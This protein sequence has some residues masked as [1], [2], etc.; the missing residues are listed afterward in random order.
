MQEYIELIKQNE[1]VG[2]IEYAKKQL[3]K[4]DDD[5]ETLI[6]LSKILGLIAF[7]KERLS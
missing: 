7:Q 5:Q 4:F 6:V 2:A 1:L 3:S